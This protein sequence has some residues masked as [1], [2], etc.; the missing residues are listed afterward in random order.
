[1][2]NA[3]GRE[4]R[5]PFASRSRNRSRAATNHARVGANTRGRRAWS[6]PARRETETTARAEVRVQSGVGWEGG[7]WRPR[8][9]D[10]KARDRKP[11]EGETLGKMQP[12]RRGVGPPPLPLLLL[13]PLLLFIL[14][15]P[16]GAHVSGASLVS[17]CVFTAQVTATTTT[18]E[19]GLYKLNS[20]DTYS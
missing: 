3:K 11:K 19:V 5:S 10:R 17:N 9:G 14:P 8:G 12:K 2:Q 4:G 7:T 1:M 6:V 15:A 16:A 20:I 13:L 18:H